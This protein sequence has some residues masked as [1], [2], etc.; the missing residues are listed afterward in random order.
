M[1]DRLEVDSYGRRGGPTRADERDRSAGGADGRRKLELGILSESR[2]T[3]ALGPPSR[4]PNIEDVGQWLEIQMCSVVED[5][6]VDEP[7]API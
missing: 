2:G 3:E 4:E 5:L 1:T 6:D 7:L